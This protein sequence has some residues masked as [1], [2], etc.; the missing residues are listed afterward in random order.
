MS[1]VELSQHGT[2]GARVEHISDRIHYTVIEF[3]QSG[4]D[5]VELTLFYYKPDD[6]KATIDSLIEQLQAIRKDMP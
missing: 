1:T 6:A 5:G 4:S 3:E 2:T